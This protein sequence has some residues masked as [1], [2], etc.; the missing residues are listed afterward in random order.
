MQEY[1]LKK[2]TKDVRNRIFKSIFGITWDEFKLLDEDKQ[3]ELIRNYN[4]SHS[5]RKSDKVRIMI[6]EGDSSE[7]RTFDRGERVRIGSGRDLVSVRAGETAKEQ[8]ERLESG[9]LSEKVSIRRL[10]NKFR[11]K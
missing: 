10:I 7:F 9:I 11:D 8:I 1:V 6:G 4:E 5:K 3:Q 2:E